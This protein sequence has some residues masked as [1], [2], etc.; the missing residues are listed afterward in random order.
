MEH[1]EA[2]W[3]HV[4]MTVLG[5]EGLRLSL[6]CALVVMP[7]CIGVWEGSGIAQPGHVERCALN[8]TIRKACVHSARVLSSV[9]ALRV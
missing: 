3:V 1:R 2:S 4:M 6:N 8:P 7:G 9:C 5:A